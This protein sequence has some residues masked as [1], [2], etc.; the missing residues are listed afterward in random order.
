M[1]SSQQTGGVASFFNE[2]PME[3]R[4]SSTLN[5]STHSFAPSSTELNVIPNTERKKNNST[6]P[7]E[8]QPSPRMAIKSPVMAGGAHLP[9]RKRRPPK[10]RYIE[11]RSE[12][13]RVGE[14]G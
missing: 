1:G 4:N 7:Q 10:K 8:K 2:I 11:S 12:E 5:P 6:E 9:E 13:G 14:R 3:T